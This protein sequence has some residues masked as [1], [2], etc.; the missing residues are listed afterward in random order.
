MRRRWKRV[1]AVLSL[2]AVISIS[3]TYAYFS[4]TLT[5]TNHIVTGDIDISLKEYE[6]TKNGE[7]PYRNSK[8]VMPGDVVSKI[9]RIINAAQP[10]WVRVRVFC[11]DDGEDMEGLSC[12]EMKG[13]S[14]DWVKRGEYYYYTKILEKSDS[15]DFFE[16]IAIPSYWTEEHASRRLSMTVQADAIQAKNFRPDFAAM[17]PWGNQEIEL[18]VHERNGKLTCRK[19]NVRLSVVFH[20]KA[21]KLMS[22][23]DDFFI[24]FQAAMPGDTFRDSVTVSN[25]T[26]KDAEIFFRTGTQKQNAEQLRM[27]N[28][29]QLMIAMNGKTLYTGNLKAE[30][31]QKNVSLGVFKPGQSG[32]LDFAVKVPAEWKNSYALKEASVKWI[33]TVNESEDGNHSAKPKSTISPGLNQKALE[34]ASESQKPAMVKTGDETA[35]AGYLLFA[36][37]SLAVVFCVLGRRKGGREK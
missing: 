34:S 22:V 17:S 20:G 30:G 13:I 26:E 16:K 12:K 33:F 2:A 3:G 36:F 15:V 6:L 7:I 28:E 5:V 4:D 10:C 32:R 35:I 31:M 23:P 24:N 9:P 37:I 19:E 27:L 11:S 25:T 29:M 8:K 1:A 18:C 14:K 21:H